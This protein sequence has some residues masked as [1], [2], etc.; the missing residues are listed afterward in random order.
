MRRETPFE[1]HRAFE[2]PKFNTILNM[3]KVLI[4]VLQE[5]DPHGTFVGGEWTTTGWNKKIQNIKF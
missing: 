1:R 3:A 4:P 5:T 2:N